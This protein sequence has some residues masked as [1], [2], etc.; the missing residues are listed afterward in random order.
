LESI[1][2][3]LILYSDGVEGSLSIWWLF[4]PEIDITAL[5]GGLVL[6]LVSFAAAYNVSP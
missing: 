1:I 5:I 6:A 3:E 2:A 4:K